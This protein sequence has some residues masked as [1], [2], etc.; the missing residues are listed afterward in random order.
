MASLPPCWT[1]ARKVG[2]DASLSLP[3][4]QLD[5]YWA[6]CGRARFALCWWRSSG[7]GILQPQNPARGG[8][9]NH[10]RA[11]GDG[12]G[13]RV[14]LLRHYQFR[15]VIELAVHRGN[16]GTAR[17]CVANGHFCG[18]GRAVRWGHLDTFLAVAPLPLP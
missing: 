14:P 2:A 1:R 7:S 6:A 16:Y 15:A 18:F 8:G 9:C 13:T 10:P 11:G 12:V 5:G 4:C 17:V 3:S